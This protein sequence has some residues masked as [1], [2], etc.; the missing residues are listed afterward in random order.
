MAT[1]PKSKI[2]VIEE[3]KEELRLVNNDI[4]ELSDENSYKV[5]GRSSSYTVVPIANPSTE[6]LLHDKYKLRD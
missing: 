6:T 3:L 2:R 1:T 5:P 4:K